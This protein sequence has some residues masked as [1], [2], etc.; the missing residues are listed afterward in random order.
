MKIPQKISNF[1]K[2][3]KNNLATK[4]EEMPKFIKKEEKQT[5]VEKINSKVSSLL[6]KLEFLK[7]Q[8]ENEELT[9]L[10]RLKLQVKL[11]NIE[12]LLDKQLAY[13][14]IEKFKDK[15][16]QIKENK[17]KQYNEKLEELNVEYDEIF[18]KQYELERDIEK[19][20]ENIQER[21]NAYKSINQ[22]MPESENSYTYQVQPRVL[23]ELEEKQKELEEV[24]NQKDKKQEQIL[25]LQDQIE[26]KY[27]SI[28]ET[29]KNKLKKYSPM[30]IHW[31]TLKEFFSR[32]KN[33]VIEWFS[34]KKLEK[35]AQK[36]A[37]KKAKQE[38][39]AEVRRKVAEIKSNE[40]QTR[41]NDFK[42]RFSANFDE[43]Q[44]QMPLEET[45]E[46]EKVEN[47][48]ETKISE[49]EQK[50]QKNEEYFRKQKELREM[51]NEKHAKLA[52]K[53]FEYQNKNYVPVDDKEKEEIEKDKQPLTQRE[54]FVKQNEM[55]PIL[56]LYIEESTKEGF[57]AKEFVNK[58]ASSENFYS[59]EQKRI[60]MQE[61]DRYEHE[62]KSAQ[63]VETNPIL[64]LYM[65]ESKQENFNEDEFIERVTFN[66]N[67]Y[68]VEQIKNGMEKIKLYK[69]ENQTKMAEKKD[70]QMQEEQEENSL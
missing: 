19:L 66:E 37:V 20:L 49:E 47:K 39:K 2:N 69:Q 43:K 15:C 1:V 17:T 3:V 23:T 46:Q 21:E 62:H 14:D 63:T 60:G 25:E 7:E 53:T 30:K 27:N 64:K 70:E 24:L 51:L 35:E 68:T 48:E 67:N 16:E 56:K 54:K 9:P 65:E 6:E 26:E 45:V 36:E 4:L 58:I 11:S 61:I 31:N 52:G 38:S 8:L 10:K 50:I 29:M 41:V 55:N 5:R 59:I 33:N 40:N 13:L 32:A 42:E 44:E 57:D 28:D 18:D 34:T 22:N 12:S